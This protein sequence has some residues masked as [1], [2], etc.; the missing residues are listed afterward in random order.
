MNRIYLSANYIIVEK[1]GNPT[2][3]EFPCGK[4]ALNITILVELRNEE[5]IIPK[6]DIEL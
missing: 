3:L 5:L 1:N 6:E 2:P 4:S